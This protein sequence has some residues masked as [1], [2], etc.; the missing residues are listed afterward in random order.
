LLSTQLHAGT[1]SQLTHVEVSFMFSELSSSGSSVLGLQKPQSGIPWLIAKNPNGVW[2]EGVR[3][4]SLEEGM[5][6]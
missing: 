3:L 6:G 2:H 1:A 5:S 4:S